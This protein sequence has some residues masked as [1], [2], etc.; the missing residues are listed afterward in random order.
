MNSA[1]YNVLRTTTRIFVLLVHVILLTHC[2]HPMH[3]TTLQQANLLA[4]QQLWREAVEAYG[5]IIALEPEHALAH[6]NVAISLVKMGEYEKALTHLQPA[7]GKFAK[8]YTLN[9]YAGEAYRSIGEYHQA[10]FHYHQAETRRP[11]MTPVALGLAWSLFKLGQ[12]ETAA[13]YSSKLVAQEQPELDA[14]VIHARILLAQQKSNEAL[15]FIR[16]TKAQLDKFSLSYLLSLEGDALFALG[17]YHAA[18][19][20]YLRAQTENSLL[21]SPL[22]GLAKCLLHEQQPQAAQKLLETAVHLRP[23]LTEAHLLLGGILE[24]EKPVRAAQHYEQFL[25]YAKQEGENIGQMESVK[26]KLKLL[27]TAI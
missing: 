18:K 14:I 20:I 4:R 9:Y 6:R 13:R 7:L 12:F 17:D 2:Q 24:V 10:I 3:P 15:T 21:A 8:D 26:A 5:R 16:G 25:K 1:E 23:Q 19:E 27:N 22:L 11:A